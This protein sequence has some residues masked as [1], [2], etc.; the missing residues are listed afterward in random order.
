MTFSRQAAAAAT[1]LRQAGARTGRPVI[2]VTESTAA[3]AILAHAAPTIGAPLFPLDP[4]LPGSIIED[5]CEQ[6][7]GGLVVGDGCEVQTEWILGCPAGTSAP[8]HP[9]RGLALL[10]AIPL[11]TLAGLATTALVMQHL[12]R[13]EAAPG[14]A[15]DAG[16]EG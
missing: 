7:G 9:P 13:S 14:T 8:W 2:A 4:T 1:L 12:A 5:L 10:I 6:V 16:G 11:S 3:L 15:S